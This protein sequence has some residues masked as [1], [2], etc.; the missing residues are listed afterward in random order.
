MV[1]EESGC[2]FICPDLRH[3]LR[4]LEHEIGTPLDN[5]QLKL[6]LVWYDL[7]L[8]LIPEVQGLAAYRMGDWYEFVISNSHKE[9]R[10]FH[11]G[12]LSGWD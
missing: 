2:E 12:F 5:P 3:V 10:N 6:S 8:E 4:P 1:R 7:L 9:L 11:V